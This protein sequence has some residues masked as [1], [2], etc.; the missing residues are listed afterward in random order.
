MSRVSESVTIQITRADGTIEPPQTSTS[1]PAPPIEAPPA[2]TTYT[3]RFSD[4]TGPGDVIALCSTYLADLRS[5]VA[6]GVA[7]GYLTP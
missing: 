1:E 5:I 4:W 7:K 6:D 2:T 3:Y